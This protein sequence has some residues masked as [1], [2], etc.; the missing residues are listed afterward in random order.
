MSAVTK[1]IR[2]WKSTSAHSL[3]NAVFRRQRSDMPQC[4]RADAAFQSPGSLNTRG[5]ARMRLIW[6]D[7]WFQEV[8]PHS[9]AAFRVLF[10]VY[11]LLYFLRFAP[12][13]ELLFSNRG[14]YAPFLV[15]DLGLPVIWAWAL[16][17]MTIAVILAFTAGWKTRFTTPLLLLLYL[18]YFF[19]N[20][21]ANN[22]AFDRLNIIML[23]ILCFAQLD[24]VWALKTD[25]PK[26]NDSVR[27]VCV[28]PI[29]LITLQIALLYFGSGLWKLINPYW[30]TGEMMKWTLIG[31]WAS[32]LSFRFGRLSL[33][34]RFYDLL[35][36][37]IIGFELTMPFALFSKRLRRFAFAIGFFFHLSIALLLNIPEFMNCVCAYV[38]FVEPEAIERN[39]QRLRTAFPWPAFALKP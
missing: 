33:P 2:I 39:M 5:A 32:D 26:A 27:F 9:L 1:A 11:F 35:V 19:L 14:V 22:S 25:P 23:A 3:R 24:A 15:P 10:G 31:P 18:Y 37:S 12:H 21:A 13:V 17:A 34:D 8:P 7:F 30:H 16:Y 38:L 4:C 36:W 20:F 29:R 6:N 28:W